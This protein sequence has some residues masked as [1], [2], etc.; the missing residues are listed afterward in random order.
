[1]QTF[2]RSNQRSKHITPFR[3]PALRRVCEFRRY[4]SIQTWAVNANG[5]VKNVYA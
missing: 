3:P 1:M 4:G 5:N 2:V